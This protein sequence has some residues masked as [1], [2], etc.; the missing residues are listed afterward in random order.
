MGGF[1]NWVSRPYWDKVQLGGKISR[2][3]G[4]PGTLGCY[5]EVGGNGRWYTLALTSYQPIRPLL[6]QDS[7]LLS[8][9]YQEGILVEQGQPPSLGTL[10][11]LSQQTHNRRKARLED[12]PASQPRQSARARRE[13][14]DL[15]AFFE[16]GRHVLGS[17]WAASDYGPRSNRGRSINWALIDVRPERR[18]TNALPDEATWARRQIQCPSPVWRPQAGASSTRKLVTSRDFASSGPS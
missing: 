18:G 9:V 10:G 3:S 2:S 6:T 8:K 1:A 13:L 15:E 17:L 4:L 14:S 7:S 5:V 16:H 11:H 12:V